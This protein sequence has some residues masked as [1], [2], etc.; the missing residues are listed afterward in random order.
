MGNDSVTGALSFGLIDPTPANYG[1]KM[2]AEERRREALIRAGIDS[3]NAVYQGGTAPQYSLVT[4]TKY[5][6]T[7]SYFKPGKTGFVPYGRAHGSSTGLTAGGLITSGMPIIGGPWDLFGSSKSPQDVFR[8]D[9]HAGNVF[10]ATPET[11]EGFGNIVGQRKQ[12]YINYAMPQLADQYRNTQNAVEYGLGNR[13]LLGGSASAKA[14]SDLN[15][16]K[17]FATQ[18]IADTG[19]SQAQ[20]LQDQIEASRENLIQQLYQT[21]NPAGGTQ[22]AIANAARFQ[23]P[24]AFAPI[25]NMFGSLINQYATSRFFNPGQAQSYIMPDQYDYNAAGAL[26]KT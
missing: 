6:P 1:G 20:S 18:T 8:G 23:Q 14:A 26:P 4:N 17:T 12:D 15:R 16:Q 9:V 19:T 2:S 21:A 22:A 5:D 24:S 11:Y 10:E 25:A 13:G 7:K 3:I